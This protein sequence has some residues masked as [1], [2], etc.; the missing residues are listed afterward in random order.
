MAGDH[1]IGRRHQSGAG[2]D[3]DEVGT[4]LHVEIDADERSP[5][6]IVDGK[7]RGVT[8]ECADA[9]R[10]AMLGQGDGEHGELAGLDG[11]RLH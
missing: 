4:R 6:A 3:R 9:H 7:C 2:L 1:E 8:V 11:P 10:I 5:P